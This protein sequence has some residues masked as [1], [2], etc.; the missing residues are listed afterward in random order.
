MNDGISPELC[1][2]HYVR[3][4]DVAWMVWQL[5]PGAQ[6]AKIDIKSAYQIVSVHPQDRCLLGMKWDGK[7]YVDTALPFGL[8]SA[9]KIF[10]A[11]ADALEWIARQQGAE[12]LWHYLD[13]YITCGP[14]G[15]D[16]CR[17][18]LSLLMDIC[19]HL[20]VP[21]AEEKIEGPTTTI[22]FLGIVID[23]MRGE[24]RLSLEK[25]DR[26]R[27]QL[28]D[29]LQLKRCTKRELLS[30]AGQLQHAATVVWP[31][32]TFLRLLLDLSATVA[33]PTHHISLN[34]AAWS[35]LIWWNEFL[36]DWNRV[37]LLSVLG[38]G[39]GRS[40]AWSRHRMLQGVGDV[41]CIGIHSGSRCHGPLRHARPGQYC[42]QRVDPHCHGGSDV[43]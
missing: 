33:K 29:W 31:G 22:V 3:V 43:G 37:L 12:H 39:G 30:I 21:L 26:L 2:L 7:V 24:L 1:F 16:E 36:A 41:V 38:G 28:R 15:S 20:G 10:N 13:D 4:D 23:S 14:A 32:R 5:G 35:D 18:N 27:R 8:L 34:K 17:L 6:M 11:L 9:P 42:D 25:V 40:Q 19:R